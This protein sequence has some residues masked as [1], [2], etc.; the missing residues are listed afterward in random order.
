MLFG[1]ILRK[2]QGIIL[3]KVGLPLCS[4]TSPSYKMIPNNDFLTMHNTPPFH[5]VKRMIWLYVDKT[6][7]IAV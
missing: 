7:V 6:N 3:R 1:L 5:V 2:V 4:L